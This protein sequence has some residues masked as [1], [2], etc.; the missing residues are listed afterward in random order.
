M[1]FLA[2]SS[3]YHPAVVYGGP[4]SSVAQRNAS[5]ARLGHAVAVFTTNANGT[6]DLEVP[7]GRPV[8]VDGLPVT[9]YPRWWF[10]LKKKPA[11]LF[12]SPALGRALRGLRPGDFDC[13]LLHS[14][15]GEP[16]RLAA[17]AA[18]RTG[19]PYFCHT[20]GAF[21]PWALRHQQGKKRLYMALI[22][23]RILKRAAGIVVCNQQE[24]EE[25]RRLG[26]TTPI[27]RLPWGAPVPRPEDLP[28]R[29][30]LVKIFPGL[31]GRTFLLFLSRLHPKKGLDLLI[32]AFAA[33]A[34]EFRDWLLVLAGP[35]ERGYRRRLERLVMEL[36]LS[37]RVLFTGLVTGEAKAALL[38]HADLFVLPSHSEGFPVVVAEALGTGRPLVLT[39]SCYV[40]EVAAAG[41]GLEVPPERRALIAALRRMLADD[42]LREAC[43]RQARQ[44]AA[45]KFTWE[46]VARESLA[47]FREMR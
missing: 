10:G 41:A 46:A 9:Y 34:G 31:A 38:A 32:P 12:L 21:E 13:C 16:G 23:G 29:S 11:N 36:G 40:P 22:E 15:W 19:T 5:L 6:E 18:Q 37:H 7:L 33:L 27:K 25:L 43:S 35:D 26:I 42:G 30:R 45:E 39:T 17:A 44:L 1:K 24:I 28:P 14:A 4:V 47:F 20:H 2:V 3:Y 8:P